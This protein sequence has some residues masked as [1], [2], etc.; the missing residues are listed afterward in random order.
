MNR[1][2]I[3]LQLLVGC[4]AV[5]LVTIFAGPSLE[6]RLHLARAQEYTTP[7]PAAGTGTIGAALPAGSTE[8][9]KASLGSGF[10][11]GNVIVINPGG[12]T[13]ERATIVSIGNTVVLSAP[14]KFAHAPGEKIALV[15]PAPPATG[16]GVAPD[17]SLLRTEIVVLAGIAIVLSV[18]VLAARRRA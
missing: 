1:K 5:L 3:A 17:D 15:A 8:L 12:A 13:E 10:V 14:T 2:S 4:V 18:T 16:T 7:T 11:A 6:S 9:P